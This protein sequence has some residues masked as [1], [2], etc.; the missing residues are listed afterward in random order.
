MLVLSTIL[1]QWPLLEDV[2][3][4]HFSALKRIYSMTVISTSLHFSQF[5][6]EDLWVH[7][8]V[9]DCRHLRIHLLLATWKKDLLGF[10]FLMQ[11][12]KKKETVHKIWSSKLEANVVSLR[13]QNYACCGQFVPMNTYLFNRDFLGESAK[14]SWVLRFRQHSEAVKWEKKDSKLWSDKSQ[15]GGLGPWRATKTEEE[16]KGKI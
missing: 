11:V 5:S 12:K 16:I 15:L 7:G 9:W 14:I 13:Q 8:F 4:L 6:Y 3:E 2:K 10:F 1:R